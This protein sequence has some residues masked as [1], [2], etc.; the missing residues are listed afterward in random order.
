VSR[1]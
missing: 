1:V